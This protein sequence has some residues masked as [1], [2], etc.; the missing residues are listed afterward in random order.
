M[1]EVVYLIFNE[2]YTATSGD[3]LDAPGTCDEALRLG[4]MLAELAPQHAEAHGL[5]ALLEIQASRNAAR[6]RPATAGRCCWPI[7]TVA[8]GIAC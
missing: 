3:R 1:L 8:A 6:D 7:R 4:R 5:V 2:G